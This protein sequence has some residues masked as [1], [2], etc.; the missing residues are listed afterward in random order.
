MNQ[1]KQH[2]LPSKSAHRTLQKSSTLNR[3]YVKRP[4]AY[5]SPLESLAS[6]AIRQNT[7][8]RQQ[9]S[10]TQSISQNIETASKRQTEA[11]KRRQA[12]A[13]QINQQNAAKIRQKSS[14]A[15]PLASASHKKPGLTKNHPITSKKPS[16]QELKNQAIARALKNAQ[17][18]S[19]SNNKSKIQAPAQAQ[20]KSNRQSTNSDTEQ[21]PSLSNTIKAKKSGRVKK[22]IFALACSTACVAAIGVLVK[23]NIPDISVRVA[24]TQTGI[25]ASYPSFIPKDFQLSSVSSTA[26]NSVVLTFKDS[27]NHSFEISEKSS[28]W[29][30]TALLNNFVKPDWGE[31]YTIIREQ[32]ITIYYTGNK[33]AWV[34]GGLLFKLTADSAKTLSKQQV[35]NIVTSL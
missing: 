12:L 23:I 4:V 2:S 34:N 6:R 16:P 7:K 1:S 5:T 25:K 14:K 35:K 32:G 24:A 22:F 11:L 18:K 3:R 30:S 9:I 26:N 20:T 15:T 28:S 17:S 10:Q 19:K 33:A 27:N 21:T 13:A 29:D 31:D 8:S